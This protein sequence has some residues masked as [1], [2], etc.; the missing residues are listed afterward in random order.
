MKK[1]NSIII[2]GLCL[3]V[4]LGVGG[5]YYMGEK[6]KELIEIERQSIVILKQTF[7]DIKEVKIE[8]TGHNKA[9]GSYRMFVEV[10]N[11]IGESVKFTYSFWKERDEIGSYGIVNTNVQK[12]GITDSKVKVTYSDGKEGEI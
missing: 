5:K 11:N 12:E 10:I 3:L 8:K 4:F 6:E 7:S 2:V 1:R 9:T